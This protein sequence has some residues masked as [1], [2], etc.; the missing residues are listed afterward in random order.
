VVGTVWLLEREGWTAR[1]CWLLRVGMAL[2]CL[3]EGLL[4]NLLFQSA[5]QRDVVASV[6]LTGIDPAVLLPVAGVAQVVSFAAVLLLRGRPLRWLLAL[7][8]AG[9][10]VVC[11]LVTRYDPALWL[12]PLGPLS[13]NVPLL[14][15][16]WLVLR[17]CA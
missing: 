5:T 12:D 17:R 8:L 4:A 13:K 16:T 11:V 10:L 3:T 7:Q 9:L 1:A 2:I 15:G 6:G 14:A